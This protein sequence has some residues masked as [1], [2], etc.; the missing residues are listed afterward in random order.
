MAD[1]GSLGA[2]DIVRDAMGNTRLVLPPAAPTVIARELVR[3]HHMAGGL[4]TLHHQMDSFYTWTGTHYRQIRKEDIR[5]TVYQVLDEAY[6]ESKEGRFVPFNP[7][8]TKVANVMEALAAEVQLPPITRAPAWTDSGRHPSPSEILACRNGLL[9]LPSRTLHPHSPAFFNLNAVD[10]DCDLDAQEPTE[11]LQF[12]RSVWANDE[13]M[14]RTLQE[15]FG[16]LLTND[17]RYQKMFLMVGPPRSGKGTIARLLHALLGSDHVASPTLSSLSQN[18]G[19]A[20]LI[21]KPLAIVSDARISANQYVYVERLLAISG[22]D[23]ITIDRKYQAPWTGRLPTRFLIQTNELPQVADASGAFASRFVVLTM[24]ESFV[25]REDHHLSERLQTERTAILNWAMIGRDRLAERGH[26][27]QPASARQA[28]EELG[29]LTSPISAFLRT[30]CVVDPDHRVECDRLFDT[31]KVWCEEQGRG[32]AATK[33]GL[34]RELRAA[35]PKM[36]IT[37]PRAADGSR[38]RY[39]Q[40][41]DLNQDYARQG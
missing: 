21:G 31:W 22:E 8:K 23:A 32:R 39:Y 18:F 33:Q 11:W 37:Q 17:T 41:L 25:N 26:F 13:E 36:E 35:L 12:L 28:K 10:Y 20:S 29:E 9:H 34:G 6:C 5:A 1:F 16:L 24:R 27:V 40:G 30:C 7:N 2:G 19:A 15:M 4:H 38:S 3:R 14:I